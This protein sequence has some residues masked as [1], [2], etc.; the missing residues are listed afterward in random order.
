MINSE[1]LSERWSELRSDALPVELRGRGLRTL[2]FVT[3]KLV[4]IL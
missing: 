3:V 1:T 2:E 4:F